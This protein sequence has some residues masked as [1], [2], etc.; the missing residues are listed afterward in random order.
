MPRKSRGPRS[1]ARGG[2]GRMK[3]FT[4]SFL[5]S[6]SDHLWEMPDSASLRA[7]TNNCNAWAKF[8]S[9]PIMPN[10]LLQGRETVGEPDCDNCAVAVNG[11][12]TLYAKSIFLRFTLQ[13]ISHGSESQPKC[14]R[15]FTEEKVGERIKFHHANTRNA[16]GR[17]ST[18]LFLRHC[19]TSAVS[20]V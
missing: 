8:C 4:T 2:V 15:K 11:S 6:Y 20:I 7:C 10:E 5:P 18:Q 12:A 3:L 1:L 16:A 19:Y 17:Q 13:S 14:G 9:E